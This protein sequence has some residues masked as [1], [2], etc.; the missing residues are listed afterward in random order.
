[1]WSVPRAMIIW[2]HTPWWWARAGILS[3]LQL[4]R[5]F[6]KFKFLF[7][8]LSIPVWSCQGEGVEL[9]QISRW[10]LD[11]DK[12]EEPSCPSIFTFAPR[13]FF[14]RN[15]PPFQNWMTAT[16][17]TFQHL[18]QISWGTTWKL[19]TVAAVKGGRSCLSTIN[20]LGNLP[21]LQIHFSYCAQN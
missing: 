4:C 7:P 20:K 14:L 9:F 21:L 12:V 10:Q 19:N 13:D 1:M 3:S 6:A 17:V 18:E 8:G 5:K 16:N 2:L 11:T 15:F